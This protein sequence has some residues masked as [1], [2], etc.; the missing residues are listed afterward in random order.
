M[1]NDV[2]KEKMC[3]SVSGVVEGRHGFNPLGEVINCNDDVFFFIAGWRV[4]SHE[5]YASFAKGVR[6]N[7]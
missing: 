4:A 6:S 5:V 1:G 2:V 7:D 3:R